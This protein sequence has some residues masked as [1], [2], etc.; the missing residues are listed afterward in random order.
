MFDIALGHIGFKVSAGTSV[1][2]ADWF[3]VGEADSPQQEGEDCKVAQVHVTP[4]WLGSALAM[5]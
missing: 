5:F 2:Q 3:L 4:G 1:S